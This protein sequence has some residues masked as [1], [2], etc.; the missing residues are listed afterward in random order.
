MENMEFNNRFM[1][2]ALRSPLGTRE[3]Q[4]FPDAYKIYNI[5]NQSYCQFYS[6]LKTII[7]SILKES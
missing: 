7:I 3:F 6:N 1:I 5:V 4:T 2:T